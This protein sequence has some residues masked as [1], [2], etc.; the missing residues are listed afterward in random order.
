MIYAVSSFFKV[1]NY[2]G[3][4]VLTMVTVKSISSLLGHNAIQFGQSAVSFNEHVTVT[5]MDS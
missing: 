5:F 1:F 4:E 3:L 2:V